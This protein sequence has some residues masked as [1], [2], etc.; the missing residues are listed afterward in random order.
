MSIVIHAFHDDGAD[1]SLQI[2]NRA[3]A[4]LQD[5][6]RSTHPELVN[7]HN[8][9]GAHFQHVFDEKRKAADVYHDPLLE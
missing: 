8:A 2:S 4:E 1:I 3:L 9:I 6:I 7:L 5:M